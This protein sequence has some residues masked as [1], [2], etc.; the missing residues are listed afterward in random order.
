MKHHNIGLLLAI[1]LMLPCTVFA[2]SMSSPSYHSDLGDM[3][4]GA[5]NS[6]S[7]GYLLKTGVVGS[8][9]S[10]VPLASSSGYNLKP[11]ILDKAV[12]AV[13]PV[14]PVIPVIPVIP[15]VPPATSILPTG[16]INGDGKV[17]VADALLALQISVGSVAV[18]AAHLVNGDVAP[19]V[20]A[21]PV[22]DGIITVADALVILRK[23]VGLVSW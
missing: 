5:G 21:K 6:A 12:V 11:A 14:V 17:D 8:A 9:I 13:V 1:L 18:T 2:G 19:L 22:P 16:D 23:V 3:P 20:G 7:L 10:M 15:V 4:A